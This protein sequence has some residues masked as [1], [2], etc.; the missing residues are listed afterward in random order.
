MAEK[1]DLI[2]NPYKP[3]TKQGIIE[4]VSIL[5]L[6]ITDCVLITYLPDN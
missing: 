2:Y 1:Y 5:I 3:I 6:K 4:I